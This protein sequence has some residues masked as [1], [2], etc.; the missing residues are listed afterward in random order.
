MRHLLKNIK[1]VAPCWFVGED[2]PYNWDPLE[3]HNEAVRTLRTN[4]KIG[5]IDQETY[6]VMLRLY[7]AEYQSATR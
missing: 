1:A 6:L 3:I 7:R 5:S 4:L 2:V